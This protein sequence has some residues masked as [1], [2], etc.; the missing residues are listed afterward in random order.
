MPECG[1]V[2]DA[3]TGAFRLPRYLQTEEVDVFLT[4]AH[5][6]HSTGLTYLFSVLAEHPLKRLTIHGE[7]EKLSGIKEHLF[8]QTLFPVSPPWEFRPLQASRK[9]DVQKNGTTR[10]IADLPYG[11]CLSSF[12][13]VHPGGSIGIRLDWPD[14]SMAYVTDT[15]ARIDADYLKCI[16]GVDLLVHECYYPDQYSDL[17]VK[18]GHSSLS[19]VAE[20][21]KNARVGRLILT[22]LNPRES[23][24]STL[25]IAAASRI[26]SPISLAEDFQE[27][28]F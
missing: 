5:L 9:T 1:I 24:D 15:T 19:A 14:R 7:V 18:Y 25:D 27:V 26:F 16:E 20:V 8:S 21:A 4:H 3:G 6:D 28:E 11:G 17:A 10:Q 22:H 2:L 12:P 23:T 13:L